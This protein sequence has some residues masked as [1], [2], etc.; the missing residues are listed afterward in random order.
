MNNSPADF[1]GHSPPLQMAAHKARLTRLPRLFAN[2]PVFFVTACTHQRHRLLANAGLHTAFCNFAG[3]APDHGVFVGRYVLMPDHIHLFVS[4]APEA[5]SLS[6]WIKS[7]K[8]ALSKTLRQQQVPAPHWQKG[9]FDHVLRS[10][11]SLAEKWLYV[12]ANPVRAGLV[13]QTEDWPFQG[14]IHVLEK[15]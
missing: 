4:S 13:K 7:L 5:P 9:F 14:E 15:R 10:D 1:G 3:Q 11:E 2:I 12:S 8:N 6:A